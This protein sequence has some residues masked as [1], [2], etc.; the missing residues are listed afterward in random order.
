MQFSDHYTKIFD[1]DCCDWPIRLEY[2]RVLCN[3]TIYIYI[4][5]HPALAPQVLQAPGRHSGR[6]PSA[7]R[8]WAALYPAALWWNNNLGCVLAPP[9]S[10]TGSGYRW[11]LLS[12]GRTAGEIWKEGWLSLTK[13]VITPRFYF[14][15]AAE[16]LHTLYYPHLTQIKGFQTYI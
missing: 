6:P 4:Y 10:P 2:S 13:L 16:L 3:N 14:W 11:G 8:P 1:R 5:T 15:H 7:P 12:H 9:S